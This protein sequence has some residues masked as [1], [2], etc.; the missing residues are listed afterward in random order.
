MKKRIISL[1][2]AVIM[3]CS[4]LPVAVLAISPYKDYTITTNTQEAVA[5]VLSGVAEV[6]EAD[7]VITIKL[8]ANVNG[9]I[10]FG[11]DDGTG[12]TGNY[13]L[14]LYGH[15]IDAGT[16][17][18]AVCADNDFT[19]SVTITGSGTLKTGQNNIIY[20]WSADVKI[21]PQAGYY[22]TAKIGENNAFVGKDKITEPVAVS[23]FTKGT[24]LVL[25]QYKD[26][27]V[28]WGASADA[29]TG[30]GSIAQALAADPAPAYIQLQQDVTL[31]DTAVGNTM[32]VD[33][34][35][36]TLAVPA[37]KTATVAAEK[38]LTIKNTK[39]TGGLDISG[40]V[41]VLG[42]LDISSLT[43]NEGGLLG[44]KPG[45]LNLGENST[46]TL[47]S[48]WASVKPNWMDYNNPAFFGEVE[49]GATVVVGENTYKYISDAKAWLKNGHAAVANSGEY[50][51]SY[52]T[53]LEAMTAAADGTSVYMINSFHVTSGETW[54]LTKPVIV[55]GESDVEGNVVLKSADVTL[56][57]EAGLNITTD[58][59]ASKVVYTSG[60]Y[61]VVPASVKARVESN[62]YGDVFLG[63][64][65]I[66]VGVSKHG[67]FG[68]Y[69]APADTSFHP[70]EDGDGIG[71]RVD[72][73]GWGTGNE[74]TT[75]DFFLP[76]TEEER[77]ILAYKIGDTT[78]EFPVAER[79]NDY[80]AVRWAVE[81][82]VSDASDVESGKLKAVVKGETI[83]G[84]EIEISY[85]FGV[86]DKMFI[87]DVSITNKG[88][89]DITDARFVRSF[90]PDMDAETESEYS[91]YNKV[92]CNPKADD[93]LTEGSDK[94]YAM[95]VARGAET[96]EGFFFI[97]FDERARASIRTG[98]GLSPDSA[99]EDYLWD[100]ATVTTDT[101][102]TAAA[103]NMTKD[104][105]NGYA[106][107]DDAIA[108]TFNLGTIA[109]T[110]STT[111]QY[112]S[113]LDPDVIT[114]LEKL[115]SGLV[116]VENA[117]EF[118]ATTAPG[119]G[120]LAES[121]KDKAGFT[122]A[123]TID[124][125]LTVTEK[126]SSAA[127]AAEIKETAPEKTYA[128]V[129]LALTASVDGAAPVDIGDT[130]TEI[131]TI[132]L[133]FDRTG[134]YN[135]RVYRFHDGNDNAAV[136]AGE[137]AEIPRGAE[138]AVAGE[139]C[140]IL[141]NKI[142]LHVKK[143]SLYSIGYTT[144]AKKITIDASAGTKGYVGQDVASAS[145]PTGAIDLDKAVSMRYTDT[146]VELTDSE[147]S[148]L[149]GYEFTSTN[150]VKGD[151]TGEYDITVGWSGISAA[152]KLY[153]E[154]QYIFTFVGG[155]LT[156]GS[157]PYIG[158]T[159]DSYCTIC[160][161]CKDAA[162]TE[163]ACRNKCKLVGMNF[164]DVAAGQWYTE[165]VEYVYHHG[166]MDG[167]G[168]NKFDVKGTLSRA[169]I[170]QILYNA[171]GRPTVNSASVFSDVKN[172]AWYSDAIAWANMKGIVEGY[173]GK[174]NPSDAVTREQLA[175][176]LW[177]YAKYKGYDVSVGEDTNIL[178]YEDVFSISEYAIPAMQWACGAGI[179][180]GDGV[181]LTPKTDATRGQ[182]AALL[183]RFCE[184]T[185]K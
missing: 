145:N 92:I 37:G 18:E 106:C 69:K 5:A 183:M 90:D 23:T 22:C 104:D 40:D 105:V 64:S 32:T 127:G 31:S 163:S 70:Y 59:D 171:E 84:V 52:A 91:T 124:V 166:L 25:T 80:S 56:T 72:G 176:I 135:V 62:K 148:Q 156:I 85:S 177:R 6:T 89:A 170:V 182:A 155:K 39:S 112:Y 98:S 71:L 47:M 49:D 33:L 42:N 94:N 103:L 174:F 7:D 100:E 168:G 74:P 110:Q 158:H 43:Y 58:V 65:Y 78:Y 115:T 83:H 121:L 162:C 41:N 185:A 144:T 46:T 9:R 107:N 66:E 12:D 54:E 181:K 134:K 51:E 3:V 73:D 129:D 173:N 11:N 147:K 117:G 20:N 60:A 122:T 120:D 53:L 30:S 150:Y 10:Q 57:A 172:G 165:A 97:A 68:T 152:D 128:F 87:T 109:Q 36:F 160:S 179:F 95:V 141:S 16:R 164:T 108:L 93:A 35:G 27:E 61:R 81:P 101:K 140:E 50:P 143:F 99:Y 77:W 180:E 8:T 159:C 102:A 114:S 45:S 126:D 79:V 63:G 75:G 82:K 111:L 21:A 153:L 119:V 38:T 157:I 19:G 86:D 151:P 178:S 55:I 15:T 96:L 118:A 138:N 34:N 88:D 130:N 136:D 139:Y 132:T 175:T 169:M 184:K 44:G 14:D 4:L 133:P 29:L 167:V 17:P 26:I 67:S 76:G 1:I 28:K 48:I 131:L 154:D 116:N 125:L 123:S 146:G 137:V 2:L 142:I 149:A 24:S 161:A 113:S 13:V